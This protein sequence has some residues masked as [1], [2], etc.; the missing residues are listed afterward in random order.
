M[1]ADSILGIA[2]DDKKT[3]VTSNS[4]TSR[5]CL[6]EQVHAMMIKPTH[7][8]AN[9]GTTSVFVMEGTPCKNKWLAEN[10]VTISILDGKKVMLMH[11]CKIT[12]PG[13]P[14]MLVGHIILEMEMASLLGIRVLCKAGCKVIFN[15]EKC[16]VIL[17]NKVILTGYKDPLS[18]LWTLLICQEEQWTTPGLMK[19]TRPQPSPCE[20]CAPLPPVTAHHTVVFSYHCIAKENDVKFMHQSLC[21]PPISSLIRAIK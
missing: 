2:D 10:P 19:L 12:I 4:S 18:D 8:V 5:Q 15:D 13:L 9:T 3:V 6:T 16:Q 1:V 11:I 21:N 7:A 20:D 14:F 17:N